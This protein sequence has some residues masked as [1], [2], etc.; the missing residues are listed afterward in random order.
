MHAVHTPGRGNGNETGRKREMGTGQIKGQKE[1]KV[2]AH[3]CV[4]GD[5]GCTAR[6]IVARAQSGGVDET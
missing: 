5:S 6:G 4:H 1:G 3:G 2:N